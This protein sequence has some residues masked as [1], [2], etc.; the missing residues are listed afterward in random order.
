MSGKLQEVVNKQ[1]EQQNIDTISE[2]EIL[3]L[4]SFVVGEEEFAIP[5]LT[6]Q[7]IIK[8][9]EHTRVPRTPEFVL[10][11]FNLRGSVIPLID[12]RVKFGVEAKGKTEDMRYIVLK[13]DGETAGFVIDRLNQAIRIEKSK[14][15]PA[16]EATSQDK[17]LIEG[18]GKQN[19]R[20]ITI[21]RVPKLLERDF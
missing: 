11:V 3:Q 9:I 10:G 13:D 14:I 1:N 15:D 5:I 2:E 12:L 18:V 6:I 19:D 7:E 4:V 21:L 8:P 16:P 17:S 20:I